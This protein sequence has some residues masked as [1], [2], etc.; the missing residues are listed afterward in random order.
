MRSSRCVVLAAALAA[1]MPVSAADAASPPPSCAAST[2]APDVVATPAAVA[3]GSEEALRTVKAILPA[4]VGP[5]SGAPGAGVAPPKLLDI[6]NLLA[7]Q[8]ALVDVHIPTDASQGF[9]LGTGPGGIC[10]TPTRLS[11]QLQPGVLSGQDAVLFA[12]TDRA[13]STVLRPTATGAE[14]FTVLNDSTAPRSFSWH[15]GLGVGQKLVTLADGTVAIVNPRPELPSPESDDARLLMTN[16]GLDA[17]E[18]GSSAPADGAAAQAG[19]VGQTGA[20]LAKAH[21]VFGRAQNSTGDEVVLVFPKPWALDAQGHAVPATLSAT[22][23][24][25]TMAVA[26]DEQTSFPVVADPAPTASAATVGGPLRV[27]TFNIRSGSPD[28]NKSPDTSI[29]RHNAHSERVVSVLLNQLGAAALGNLVHGAAA[30]QEVCYYD[31]LRI[32]LRINQRDPIESWRGEFHTTAL[33]GA[34]CP[35]GRF[36]IA[37]VRNTT[38]TDGETRY[39]NLANAQYFAQPPLTTNIDDLLERFEIRGYERTQMDVNGRSVELFNTHLAPKTASVQFN[40][41][42][43]L[44]NRALVFTS[45]PILVAGDFNATPGSP[46]AQLFYNGGFREVDSDTNDATFKPTDTKIDYIFIR[47]LHLN[48]ASVKGVSDETSDHNTL[49]SSTDV[50]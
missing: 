39:Y 50:R 10:L 31:Y 44:R 43:T 29:D 11:D 35:G 7:S 20:E 26:A 28:R 25:I 21:D 32:L 3:Q 18:P 24:T 49:V 1:W 40:Q 46:P 16:S 6:G 9:S 13:T 2:P 47:G 37:I 15:V 23:D 5:A 4:A 27:L 19:A 36:G 45:H 34:G 12:D 41:A 38:R 33:A 22:A 14:S 30:L 42:L 8:G 17:L 48:G